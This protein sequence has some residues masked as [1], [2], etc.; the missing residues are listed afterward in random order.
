MINLL[1]I[2]P[3]IALLAFSAC[4]NRKEL[5][6][7]ETTEQEEKQ[8]EFKSVFHEANSEKMIGHNEKAINLFNQCLLLNPN[9]AASYFGL[10]E[11]YLK[12]NLTEKAIEFGQKAY[13]LNKSNKWYVV[14]LADLFYD[15]GNY[16]QSAKF[17]GI[18]ID[19]FK[20]KNIEYRYK[21]AESLIYS[22]NVLKAIQQLNRIEL[23]V[24]KSPELSL[25]KHDLYNSIGK[26][27]EANL[28]IENLLKDF[29]NNEPIREKILNYYLQTNQVDKAKQIANEILE[30]NTNNGNALL[31]LADIEIR[32]NN[33]DKSFD[34]LN[35]GFNTDNVE[36]ERKISLLNGLTTY[37]FNSTDESSVLI[38]KR[39]T[40]LFEK[41]NETESD[42]ADFIK[43]YAKY[44]ELNK[45][46]LK[47]RELFAKSCQIDPTNFNTWNALLNLDYTTGLYDSLFVDGQ[48]AIEYFPSQPIV[49]L[50]TGIGAYKSN[51]FDEAEEFLFLGKDLVINDPELKSEFEYHLGKNYWKQGE[52][53]ESENY[54]EK[55]LKT[56]PLN[57]KIH[58]GYALLLLNDN[59]LDKA[60]AEILKALSIDKKNVNYLDTYGL[61]LIAKK[62]FYLAI[63]QFKKAI[64]IEY[65]NPEVL[66]HYGDAFFYIGNINKAIDMWKESK[67]LGN[68]SPILLKKITNKKI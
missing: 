64:E 2:L 16:H 39:L 42:N 15:T 57:A 50:L 20:E 66:E 12:Q 3:I 61:V 34:Y 14:H 38:N 28:E 54:F 7:N 55:A 35:K 32:Q 29:P 45:N 6:K 63:N 36:T 60:E 21:Y 24:G 25:T 8:I 43:L 22:N 10:S 30:L 51:K 18:L 31:G 56:Y 49:Y 11:I 13:A 1:K 46:D 59:Q 48:K 41:L 33:I 27:K 5:A 47:A 53:D 68:T 58:N 62:Q 23:E 40:P 26:T 44:L 19:E 67:R 65:D 37:A 4:I 9:S 52:K 17:Y